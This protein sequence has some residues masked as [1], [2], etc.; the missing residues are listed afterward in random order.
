LQKG[1]QYLVQAY[2]KIK[3]PAKSLTFVGSPSASLIEALTARGLWSQ[4][5]I[6]L[7]HM[8]QTELK[9]IMSLS[10]VLVLPSIQDGFGMV[11]AQA[12]ACGCPVVAS[13]HTGAEDLMTNGLEGFIVPARDVSALTE[14]LQQLADNPELRDEM[15]EKALQKVQKIGGWHE[16][17]DKSMDIYKDVMR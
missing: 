11:M 14:K 17:G 15:A 1:V 10:H 13:N 6:V 3:H 12:M 9:N 5:A 8:P 16:Y 4:D 2:Q 7:G